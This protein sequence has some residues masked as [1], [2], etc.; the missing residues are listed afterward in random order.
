M[1]DSCP[2]EIIS[3]EEIDHVPLQNK[4]NRNRN[5]LIQIYYLY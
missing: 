2:S 5:T 1:I 4:R 3:V